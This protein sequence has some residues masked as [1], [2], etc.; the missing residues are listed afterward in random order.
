MLHWRTSRQEGQDCY[1]NRIPGTSFWLN[2][3]KYALQSAIWPWYSLTPEAEPSHA[4]IAPPYRAVHHDLR[5][6]A[7][8]YARMQAHGLPGF[9]G[10][11]GKAARCRLAAREPGR[12]VLSSCRN[13]TC[14]YRA[15][16]HASLPDAED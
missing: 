5:K 8:V 10:D 9:S 12:H 6:G 1:D 11:L 15:G 16:G 2:R 14:R 7:R 4:G 3:P 13:S